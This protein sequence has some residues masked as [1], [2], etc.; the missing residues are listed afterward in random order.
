MMNGIRV[1]LAKIRISARRVPKSPPDPL[2]ARP[3]VCA[4]A[5]IGRVR[6]KA[7]VVRKVSLFKIILWN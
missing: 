5:S 2:F 7:E 1:L 4:E 3:K 6:T